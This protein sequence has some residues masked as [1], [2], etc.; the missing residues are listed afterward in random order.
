MFS[1]AIRKR[2][3]IMNATDS[4]KK[5]LEAAATYYDDLIVFIDNVQTLKTTSS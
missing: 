5:N 3:N 1:F 4:D 2:K